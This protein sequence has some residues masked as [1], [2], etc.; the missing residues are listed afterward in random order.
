[1]VALL[2]IA[3]KLVTTQMSSKSRLDKYIL[4][5]LHN[6]YYTALTKCYH[7]TKQNNLTD[8][9]MSKRRQTQ[10]CGYCLENTY[11]LG[12]SRTGGTYLHHQKSE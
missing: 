8:N 2:P 4:A 12:T 9:I 5:Y 10:K 11:T 6:E 1:M 3:K 7:H